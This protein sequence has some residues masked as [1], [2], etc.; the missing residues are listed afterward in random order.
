[1]EKKRKV[2]LG[3]DLGI[4]SVGWAI[5]DSE[6]NQVYKLGS[7][8]FDAPDTNLE[9][10]T[11][12]G[13]RRLLRR[14]KYRNQKFYNLVKRTE[15]FGLSSREAIENRF[16][17][18]SIKYPNI[19]ELK[20]KALSQEV[21]PDEIAWI[22]H[23]YLKNRGYFYDEKETK[24][25]FDQQTIESMPSYKLNEFYKKYGYF[26]GALSQPTESEMKDNKDLKEAFFFDFSN[27]EWLKEIN[28][29]FNVQKNILSETFIEEFKKIFSFTRDI[30]KG[31]GSDNMPS[32]YGIFG[33]FGDNGQGGRY[34]HI[35]DKNIGKCSIF[36][37]EQ[38]AP[39]YLPSALI[40][41][42]LNE[43]ANIRL[44][45][46]DKKNIQP[47]WKLS[48]IDKLNI[49]LNLF[50]L[51]ISEK[52]KKLTSANINDIV[53]KESTKSIM[54]S[55]EDIDMIKDEWAGKEP[56]VYGVGLS[57]LNIE[58]SAKENKFKFQDLKILNVLINLLDNVGIKFEFKD[59]N[60]II[61]N[62][63][64]LDNLYLFLIYQKESNNKD[65]SI[66]L[67]I[68]KNE[69][70]NI[71][72]LKLKLKEFLLGA[73]NEF[74]NHN[75]KTHSLSKKA[76][77]AIL[78]KLL[79]NNE[80]WNLEAIK[81]YDEEIK[82]QIEDNS[83]LMAKQDKKYLND[84]FL[85][86]AILP[87]NVKVTFQQAILI[88]NKII[89]KFS[90][91]F[92]IDKVVIELAREMTQDQENDALKGIAKAQKSK[93]SLVEERLEANNID[94]SVFNEKYEKLIY[95]IFLWI[96]Q[97]FKDPYTG[98]KISANEIVDN[99][100][101]IDHIIPYS[102]CFDD[103]SAN[104]VL[105]HKQS[106]QEKSNSL[107][108]EYIK[109]GHS[110]W[111]WDE[112]TKYVKRVFVN[113]VDSILSKKERLKKSEN[114]LTTSYDGY[115]KLGFLARN[116]NDTRYATIL[117]RDQLNNYAEH[118]LIDDKKMFKVI[119]MNGAVTSFIRKNMSYDNKLRLKN[120]N[121][122]SHHA[123][124]AAIIA[125]FSNKTKTLYNLIDPS[126]NGIISKRSEG[127]WVIEDRYTGE[128]KELKKEDWTSIKNNVQARK[129]AKEIEEYLIDL[130]DEVFFSRKTK[131][132]TNRQLY[133][134]TIYGIAA[135]TDE[136]GITNYYK[137]EKLSILDDKDIYLRLL[138][139]REKFV[140]NQSNPEVIDQII[141]IIESYG[142]ENNI[143]SRDEAINIKYTKNKINY[144][145][146]LK[147][148]MRSLTKSLDQFSEEFINQM[149][150]NKTF[151]LY[152]PTKNTTRKIKFLR[153]V[154]DVKINDI[155]KNQVINKFNGKNNEPKA[156]YENINSLGAIVFK[157]SAN[158]FKTL[159]INTQIAI[160]GDKNWDIEDFKTYNMEKIE[161]YKEIYGIDKTYNF[162]SFIFPG[163][164]LLDK[165]NKEFYYI[166]SIQTV[167]DIIEIKF[168]NKIE[169][170][171]E[172]KN[173]DTSK[174]PKRLMFGIKSIMNNYEQVDISPFGINKKIFE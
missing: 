166:S 127:Y 157:N 140:I 13:T 67:F 160:F 152:N 15:V 11:Q 14:R 118:H 103:S 71:E 123:Y 171:D 53:K 73:G 7:R 138:R 132:K 111:N 1:M 141:E 170:K 59:R 102:L 153:L 70:L 41:N 80:G 68:A 23:D 164:I 168:L 72:N 76:I 139:E 31:P 44:Y 98:A 126:L 85:K 38:R 43:L 158:N 100:V 110:G 96:S 83:F 105:V 151:V 136:D 3:F 142:K 46:T 125:L 95:K 64:L 167:R 18:L 77:D 81:N 8:L 133:N 137:K 99:K 146:Y 108:Y 144:N 87:P 55:V 165:Q 117:F 37:N 2:T 16:R 128:I 33:E 20:T 145:L 119:A 107:P 124:D 149:I 50:N 121:D 93:K 88:F 163:T 61:K 116:L 120:R 35:W 161:K 42:F 4:A 156:F 154:N 40:F 174:T 78:P 24:E 169:F 130:D 66:D 115:D 74:E 101:E 134:E 45:S 109:Q 173:Q 52:K 29:F 63:E 30:S 106:N 12:R 147:Q 75:S 86:D 6:T 51:P 27:K 129:I 57:G 49:L 162:H 26:K 34:E 150:A 114:L 104:K 19:I 135:K 84:N 56:N 155:R 25:D 47:L 79:D 159:S 148:Y 28:Y 94:K 112:F 131:R 36:T 69:S 97:D 60:D 172:N 54:L 10:R 122:F 17:E 89:Q 113:N 9:R 91:D 92:E 65:S 58:E 5:V 21:C 48:S 39:K 62:L 90:K 22:L 82:S 143:P 32:P